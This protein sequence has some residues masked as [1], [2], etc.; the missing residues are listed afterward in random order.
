MKGLL[1]NASWVVSN[2]GWVLWDADEILW[3]DERSLRVPS[4]KQRSLRSL[5]SGGYVGRTHQRV[6]QPARP[7]R[8]RAHVP[9]RR[10][11]A[12]LTQTWLN[13][14]LKLATIEA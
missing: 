6:E 3:N 10:I 14:Q 7:V 12:Q 13:L 11:P 2:D 1:W 5:F 8:M 9:L 4:G